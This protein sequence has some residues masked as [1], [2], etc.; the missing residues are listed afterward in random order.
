M[1]GTIYVQGTNWLS[2]KPLPPKRIP[3][4]NKEAIGDEV[5]TTL[6]AVPKGVHTCLS[7]CRDEVLEVPTTKKERRKDLL[8]T[9][10]VPSLDVGDFVWLSLAA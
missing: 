2:L 6:F 3:M 8:H 7:L 4:A 5:P 10:H 1:G 9:R